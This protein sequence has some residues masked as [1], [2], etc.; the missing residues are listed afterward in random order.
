MKKLLL[1]FLTYER[2]ESIKTA[3]AWALYY[4]GVAPLVGL[5]RRRGAAVLMLHSVGSS[6]AFSDN[7]LSRRRLEEILRYLERRHEIVPLSRIVSALE[8]GDRPPSR[9]VALTFDDGYADNFEV[10]LPILARHGAWASFFPA[11]SYLQG[12]D[13]GEG[14][15]YFFDEVE[16]VITEAQPNGRVAVEGVRAAVSLASGADR[17]DSIRRFILEIRS[18]PPQARDAAVRS[19]TRALHANPAGGDDLY[20]SWADLV[21][22][23]AAGMEVGSHSMT[24]AC[25]SALS[26]PSLADEIGGSKRKLD[27]ALSRPVEGFAFPFGKRDALPKD[28]RAHLRAAGYRYALTTEFGRVGRSTDRYAIPRIGVRDAA[29]VRLKVQLCGIPL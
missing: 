7:R 4:G 29:L 13:A 6:G 19:L 3:L 2:A 8:R 9:W 24:H 1:K 26:A 10:A 16:R 17:A 12:G 11:V 23:Q 5:F 14:G 25:L 27:E 20:L 22:I 18:R 21:R 15:R 28:A